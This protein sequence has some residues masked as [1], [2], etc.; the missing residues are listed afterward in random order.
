MTVCRR[1]PGYIFLLTVLVIGAIA[2]VAATS[3]VLLG[4][5]RQQSSLAATQSAQAL[6]F[7]RTCVERGIRSLRSDLSYDGG[8][9][10]TFSEGS[11]ILRHLAGSG[12]RDRSLCAE[13]HSANAVRRLEVTLQR[14]L[15][16]TTVDS[17]VEVSDFTGLCP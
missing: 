11:C 13:G 14:V 16:T 2:S 3:L 6:E 4:L 15:P 17:W 8:L 1:R 5:A 10:A 7:A 12:N 9:T